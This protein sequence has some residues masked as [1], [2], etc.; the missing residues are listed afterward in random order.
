MYA[1]RCMSCDLRTSM[2]TGLRG[3][4]EGGPSAY[5]SLIYEVSMK[6]QAMSETSFFIYTTI[7]HRMNTC[8]TGM[9]PKVELSLL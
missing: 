1:R 2:M 6:G 3:E 9:M 7:Q 5:D 8:D 4:G